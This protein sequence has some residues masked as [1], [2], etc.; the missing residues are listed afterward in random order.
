[1]LTE[2][3]EYGWDGWLGC[4]FGNFPKSRLTVLIGTQRTDSGTSSL[5]RKLVNAVMSDFGV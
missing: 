5:T 2:C 1:M 3:G 4:Y